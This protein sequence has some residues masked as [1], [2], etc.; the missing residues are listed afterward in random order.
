M[1][2]V[3][4][5]DL[6]ATLLDA[7]TYSWSAAAEALD[8]LRRRE[9]SIVL[10]SSKTLAEME[11][12]HRELELD[13]PFIVENGGGIVF[14]PHAPLAETLSRFPG[15]SRLPGMR[16]SMLPLGAGYDDLVVSL[17]EMA[18]DVGLPL[19]GFSSMPEEEVASLTGLH[20]R[21]AAL[22]KQRRFDEPFLVPDTSEAVSGAIE[23]AAARRGLTA[24]QGGRFWHLLGHEGKGRAVSL[25]I[26]TYRQTF[27]EVATIGLGD[28]PNDYPFLAVVDIPILVGGAAQG[29]ALPAVLAGARMTSELGPKGW[30]TAILACLRERTA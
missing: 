11:L 18:A 7:E 29:R 19:K 26:D 17:A 6:D 15:V 28:S 25:L 20:Q 8:A 27:R 22:A 3:V 9:A 10:V 21:D 13:S 14:G 12:L 30:N 24:V 5:T 4:F 1:H 2:I 23:R 16:L